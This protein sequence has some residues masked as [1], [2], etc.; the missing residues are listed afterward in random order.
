[1]P[2]EV[3]DSIYHSAGLRRELPPESERLRVFVC[4]QGGCG[5]L[6][7]LQAPLR[8]IPADPPV[9]RIAFDR[10]AAGFGD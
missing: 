5:E 7:S 3:Y 2:A 4:M 10:L 1:M 6:P 8:P 9:E